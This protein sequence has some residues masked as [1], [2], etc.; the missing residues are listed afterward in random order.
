[1]NQSIKEMLAKYS[2]RT[3]NDYKNALKEIIQEITLLGLSRQ[4]FYHKAA[5]YGGTAL[6]IAHKLNRFSEDIDFTLL[7][8]D[9]QFSLT[10]YL[11]GIEDEMASY[12]LTL[13]AVK[14]EKSAERKIESRLSKSKYT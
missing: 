12:G 8:P 2:C 5:L 9:A 7:A 14:K 4:G 11:Q 6:R 3:P 13:E 10:P 1:M